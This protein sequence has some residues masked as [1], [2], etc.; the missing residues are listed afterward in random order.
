MFFDVLKWYE[1]QEDF[2][3]FSKFTYDMRANLK[4][5]VIRDGKIAFQ[6]HSLII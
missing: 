5:L 4:K 3:T 1:K 2:N 6:A